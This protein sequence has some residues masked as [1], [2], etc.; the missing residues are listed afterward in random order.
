MDDIKENKVK[1]GDLK[2]GNKGEIKGISK[3]KDD[4]IK[5]IE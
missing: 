5:E 3:K 4:I 1:I 2:V